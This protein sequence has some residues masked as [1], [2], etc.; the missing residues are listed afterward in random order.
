MIFLKNQC[1][2]L[3]RGLVEWRRKFNFTVFVLTAFPCQISNQ[4]KKKRITNFYIKYISK[5]LNHIY[6]CQ[7]FVFVQFSQYMDHE[8]DLRMRTLVGN[9]C[10][11]RHP[12]AGYKI[13]I[14]FKINISIP[15][16]NVMKWSI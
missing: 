15:R 5:L 10:K 16:D 4:R 13:N 6:H 9:R 3:T 14:A 2:K 11:F 8:A 1:F 12:W 7:I